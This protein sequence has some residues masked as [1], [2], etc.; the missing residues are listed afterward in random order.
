M[1][2]SPPIKQQTKLKQ[3]FTI[4]H[5]NYPIDRFITFLQNTGV[6]LIIDVRSSPYSRFNPHFNRENLE[7]S[8]I[9]NDI[10][11]RYMGDKIGGRQS[12]PCL[13]FPDGTVNYRKVQETEKFQAGI[14]EVLSIISSG[15]KIALMC[16]EK[17]PE[18]CH[19]FVLISP[20]LQSRGISVIH[21]RPD[22]KLQANEDLERELI[23]SFFDTSQISI[24]GEPVDFVAEMYERVN[25]EIGSGKKHLI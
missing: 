18:R 6:D 19:R 25:R 21:I 2:G 16:A 20:V 9:M 5:G 23:D 24:T 15:K 10:D 17:E 7:K 13:L 3:C 8:L 12:D 1:S 22:M 4:G 14:N 11:Y